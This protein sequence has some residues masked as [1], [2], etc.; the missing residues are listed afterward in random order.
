MVGGADVGNGVPPH[1]ANVAAAIAP[2]AVLAAD[3]LRV[4]ARGTP[5]LSAC[6]TIALIAAAPATDG[7]TDGA[8]GSP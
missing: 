5:R 1:A 8:A 6:A 7:A 2:I 3:P 4:F